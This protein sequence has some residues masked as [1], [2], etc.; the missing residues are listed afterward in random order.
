M[1]QYYYH[2]VYIVVLI[3]ISHIALNEISCTI[4]RLVRRTIRFSKT[5]RMHDLV[6]G[7]LINRYEIGRP[8][9]YRINRCETSSTLRTAFKDPGNIGRRWL[10]VQKSHTET[11][12]RSVPR[13]SACSKV[14]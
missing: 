1:N 3:Y 13:P 6:I 4:K 5:E 12:C 8:L 10:A 7:L 11:A 2:K 9:S 14:A